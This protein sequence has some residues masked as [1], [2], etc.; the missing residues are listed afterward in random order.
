MMLEQCDDGA[1]WGLEPKKSRQPLEARK[2]KEMD[3]LLPPSEEMWS[4]PR[5]DFSPQ[6]PNLDLDP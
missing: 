6:R 3:S 2:S 4:C 5:L 1:M